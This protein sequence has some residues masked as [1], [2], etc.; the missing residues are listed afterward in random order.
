MRAYLLVSGVIFGA[1]ALLH[2]LRLALDWPVQ[3]AGWPVPLWFS[4]IGLAVAG[5]LCIW[6]VHL[7]ASRTSP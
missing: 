3:L 2:V 1:V 4:W 6:A 5:T 7:A